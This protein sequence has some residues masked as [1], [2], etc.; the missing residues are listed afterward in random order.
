M[1][2]TNYL[3]VNSSGFIEKNVTAKISQADPICF[4]IHSQKTDKLF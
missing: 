2:T 4:A 3:V 1:N